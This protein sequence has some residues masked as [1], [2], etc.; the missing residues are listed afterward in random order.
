VRVVETGANLGFAGAN[1]KGIPY[2]QGRY[3]LF[4][5][6]DAFVC[7]G[8]IPSLVAAL[9]SEPEAAVAG[10]KLLNEDGSLQYSARN[11]PTIGNQVF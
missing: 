1:N 3:V 2:A 8:A 11:F 6:P 4:L 9:D 10:P 7:D 5:N